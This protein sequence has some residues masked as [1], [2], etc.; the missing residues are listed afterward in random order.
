M[1]DH[2]STFRG[3][4]T[5]TGGVHWDDRAAIHRRGDGQGLLDGMKALNRGTLAEMVQ[6]IADMPES[7]RGDYV[8]QKAGDHK[9]ETAEIMALA[10]RED[11][12]GRGT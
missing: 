9:L 12:P 5:D 11:F 1:T 6:M 7:D 8:I 4:T 10:E 3:G 2:P